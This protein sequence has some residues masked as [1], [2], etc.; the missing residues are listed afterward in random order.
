MKGGMRIGSL[1]GTISFMFF[2][3]RNINKYSNL[4]AKVLNM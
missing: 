3:K 1:F 4:P 2:E